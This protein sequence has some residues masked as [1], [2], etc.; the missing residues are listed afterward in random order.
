[1]TGRAWID[2]VL[3]VVWILLVLHTSEGVLGRGNCLLGRHRWNRLHADGSRHCRRC[4]K[5]KRGGEL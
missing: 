3:V 1:M 2:A 5:Y 4:G